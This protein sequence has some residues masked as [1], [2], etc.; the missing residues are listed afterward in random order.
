MKR[1]KIEKI[2]IEDI[3]KETAKAIGRVEKNPLISRGEY[4]AAISRRFRVPKPMAKNIIIL[5]DDRGIIKK[6]KKGIKI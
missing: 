6:E 1:R 2:I 3:V 5:M 4:Y